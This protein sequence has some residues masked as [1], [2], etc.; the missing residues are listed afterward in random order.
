MKNP[1]VVIKA[2]EVGLTPAC[3]VGTV[4]ESGM[5]L[6]LDEQLDTSGDGASVRILFPAIVRKNRR[7]RLVI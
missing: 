6:Q 3:T 5:F 7:E 4:V 2:A 1:V